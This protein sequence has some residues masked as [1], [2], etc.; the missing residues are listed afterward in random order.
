MS[1]PYA[2]SLDP[3]ESLARQTGFGLDAVE[4]MQRAVVRGGGRM[5]QFDHREFGGPGQWMRGGLLMISDW[6]DAALKDRIGRLC[7]ALADALER[8]P[9]ASPAAAASFGDDRGAWYPAALGTPDASGSQDGLRYAWFGAARRLAIEDGGAVRV[10]DTGDHRIG[11]IAQ[12]QGAGRT[13]A[14]ASQHGPVDLARLSQVPGTGD[15]EPAEHA[16]PAAAD[17]DPFAA[18]EKL[19]ALHAR[20]IVDAAEFAAKKAELLKRI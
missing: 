12:Q 8:A 4:T 2:P 14:F 20:G 1:D 9:A 10:Y 3:V 13:L 5:A 17:P 15:I 18:L 16:D 6:N 19:A 11:G 7:E